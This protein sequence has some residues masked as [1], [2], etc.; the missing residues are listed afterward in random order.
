MDPAKEILFFAL[1]YHHQRRRQPPP[2]PPPLSTSPHELAASLSCSLRAAKAICH[3]LNLMQCGK[4]TSMII[5]SCAPD[6]YQLA[7]AISIANHDDFGVVIGG[8]DTLFIIRPSQLRLRA[9]IFTAGAIGGIALMLLVAAR[10]NT[11]P[12]WPVDIYLQDYPSA[13]QGIPAREWFFRF[14]NMLTQAAD[15]LRVAAMNHCPLVTRVF[16]KGEEEE[17]G[18][19]NTSS[20]TTTT[21]TTKICPV[22]LAGTLLNYPCIYDVNGGAKHCLSNSALQVYTAR[23]AAATATATSAAATSDNIVISGSDVGTLAFS[24][25]LP[26]L[27]LSPQIIACVSAWKAAMLGINMQVTEM[28][29]PKGSALAI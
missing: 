17:M 22:A 12:A 18:D 21:S 25:P 8:R 5:S 10:Y 23:A 29:I 1:Q 15:A 24:T 7:S 3:D 13:L 2:P 11:I 20:T 9:Y 4:R 19:N 28:N 27:S 26:L 14:S 16:D 6:P